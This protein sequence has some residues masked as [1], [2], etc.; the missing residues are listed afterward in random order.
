MRKTFL[1]LVPLCLM[2]AL[3]NPA[4]AA[5]QGGKPS[6]NQQTQ[7]SQQKEANVYTGQI[8]GKSE[9]AKTVSIEVGKGDQVKTMMLKFDEQTK[10][11]DQAV[12]GHAAIIKFEMRG[13]NKYATEIKP[14]LAKLPEGV[15]EIKTETL[16]ELLKN[17]TDMFL[18]D[19]RPASRYG[20]SHLPG[21]VSIPVALL[22]KKQ[23]AALPLNKD[24][25]IV[26]YCGGPT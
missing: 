18:V 25:L 3:I 12:K 15:T 4:F 10:G 7:Q 6:V 26:F 2:V 23:A 24:K 8:V 13:N 17:H 14:K 1:K 19:A 5:D 22:Q 21:A 11:V 20:Q 9:K 16:Q